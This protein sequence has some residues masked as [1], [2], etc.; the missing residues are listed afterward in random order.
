MVFSSPVF[1]FLFLPTVFIIYKVLPKRVKNYLLIAASLF[2]YAWG[3]PVYIL[4][5]LAS[6][7]V[8]YVMARAIG[9]GMEKQRGAKVLLAL[10]VVYNI[11]M[12][13]VFKYANFFVGNVNGIF[14]I[15]LV[16]P[17]IRLPIG[18]SFYTFQAMSYVIDVYRGTNKAQKNFANV[19][20]YIS[21]FPQLIAGPIVKYHDIAQQIEV[22][23][24]TAEKTAVGLKRFTAGL[25]KKLLIANAMGSVAD[26]VFALAPGQVNV[27]V[28]WIGALTY[29][30]QIYFDFSGYSDMAIGLAKLFGFEIKE[31]FDYPYTA[32]SIKIF[33]R[34]WHI[35]LSTWFKEYLYIP[36]G[37][38]RKGTVRTSFNL[39]FVFF[40]TGLWHGAEWTFV[41]WGF[42][43]GLFL[44]LERVGAIRTDKFPRPIA[45]VYTL[46]IVVTAFTIFRAN[47]LSQ[48]FDFIAKM[49]T[50]FTTGPDIQSF[51]SRTLTPQVI[52]IGA[53][54]II[55]STPIVKKAYVAL[56]HSR[57]NKTV[58]EAGSMIVTLALLVVC[59]L[60]LSSQTYNP[61][62][63]FRF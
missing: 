24:E 33:W 52:A 20:L 28:A 61:F 40:C 41:V 16:I 32:P 19:L 10:C 54:G 7:T 43:H 8:N 1:L 45:S 42:F 37:G 22:R 2:F 30:L 3:E 14:G 60:A 15:S 5:M 18:I 58:L 62:I 25:A 53:L 26:S 9:A 35:S 38:N 6:V 50:G 34:K 57:L 59:M 27:A 44:I 49:F 48:G 39:I 36:L 17:V 47:T 23:T 11:G 63:Y 46:L 31:N 13:F 21:F 56:K 4:L 51:I 12:L 29:S 55:G